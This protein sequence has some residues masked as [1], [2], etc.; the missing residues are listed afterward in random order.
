MAMAVRVICISRASG[1]GGEAIGKIVAERLGFLYV[2]D[3]IISLAARQ[4]QIDPS[5]VAAAEQRQSLFWRF[6]ESMPSA[7]DLAGAMT[8][9]PSIPLDPSPA[10]FRGTSEEMRTVIRGAIHMVA[11]SGRAVIV[12]HAASHALA[13][14]EGVLRVL[15]TAPAP[16]RARR[17]ADAKSIELPDAE[18]EVTASDRER[19]DYLN[20][21]YGVR[22]ELPTHYDVVVNTEMLTADQAAAIVIAATSAS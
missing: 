4:A 6:I 18:D 19:R 8:L 20:R 3:Q 16:V 14:I 17:L 21:F 12:A 1:A 5:I 13:G 15:V 9:S 7:L 22:D 11:E 2:D 10:S